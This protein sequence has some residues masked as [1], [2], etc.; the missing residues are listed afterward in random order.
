MPTYTATVSQCPGG[1]H[2]TISVKRDGV[3]FRDVVCHREDLSDMNRLPFE[4]ILY[5]LIRQTI[6]AADATTPVQ[7]KNAIE[8]ASWRW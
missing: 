7:V 2:V 6:K 5:V 4:D 3:A 8:A 1:G